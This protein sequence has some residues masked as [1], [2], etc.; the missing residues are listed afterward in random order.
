MNT[1]QRIALAGSTAA[2][3][4]L[5]LAIYTTVSN[6]NPAPRL[7][8]SAFVCGIA[9][10]ATWIVLRRSNVRWWGVVMIY[11]GMVALV[12]TAQGALR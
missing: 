12:T 3:F 11:S 4:L 1:K 7:A 2:T 8:Y 10:L 9:A 5:S 6:R